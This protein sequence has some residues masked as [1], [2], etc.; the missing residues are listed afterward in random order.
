MQPST[1][2]LP[3]SGFFLFAWDFSIWDE[4]AFPIVL[5]SIPGCNTK[6]R[7]YPEI[8]VFREVS[9]GSVLLLSAYKVH[10]CR[11]EVMRF[12]LAPGF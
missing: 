3:Q 11:A 9:G 6:V 7:V 5:K 10:R 1:T 2:I 12:D 8:K 4:L